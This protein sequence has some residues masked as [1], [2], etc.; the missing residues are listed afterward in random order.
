MNK[1]TK[2]YMKYLNFKI[3]KN[4]V[5]TSKSVHDLVQDPQG[6]NQS[7]QSVPVSNRPVFKTHTH[8][9]MAKG[10]LDKHD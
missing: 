9:T 2:I 6:V 7:K 8:E 1:F 5:S 3:N 4:R 10:N